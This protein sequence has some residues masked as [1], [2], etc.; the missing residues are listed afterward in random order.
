MSSEATDQ[1]EARSLA[2]WLKANNSGLYE[3]ISETADLLVRQAELIEDLREGANDIA[4]LL[5]LIG[6]IRSACGDFGKRRPD[7]LVEHI[8]AGFAERDQLRAEV[9]RLTLSAARYEALR[10]RHAYLIVS[11]LMG[12]ESFSSE[13]SRAQID[14]FADKARAEV[15]AFNA[16]TPEQRMN[17]L[18]AHVDTARKATP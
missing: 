15:D 7:E 2:E 9:E 14:G 8:R 10:A 4:G 12:R 17:E 5:V 18:Q 6:E 11:R 3:E 13:T 1:L 16:L